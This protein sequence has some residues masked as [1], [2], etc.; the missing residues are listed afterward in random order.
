MKKHIVWDLDGV[1]RALFKSFRER[2]NIP[3]GVYG[4]NST[5]LFLGKTIYEWAK[6]DYSFIYKSDPTEY[7]DTIK[8]C[9]NGSKI[10]IWSHQPDDWI[11]YTKKWLN[12]YLKG[13]YIIKYL[14]PEEKYRKLKD[15]PNYFLVEDSPRFPCYDRIVLIDREYNREIKPFIRIKSKE[16]LKIFLE[17]YK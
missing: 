4:Y 7:L 10:E 1:I 17:R 2:F 8:E 9:T 14:T 3:D 11:K 5:D 15:N 12:T 13:K 16:E 6:E